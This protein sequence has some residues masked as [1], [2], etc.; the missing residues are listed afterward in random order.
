MNAIEMN[1]IIS[2]NMFKVS[3]REFKSSKEWLNFIIH[4]YGHHTLAA[5]KLEETNL[6]KIAKAGVNALT[7]MRVSSFRAKPL[8]L[9]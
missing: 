9:T 3:S 1:L 4:S 2:D 6:I 8:R 7:V 5:R